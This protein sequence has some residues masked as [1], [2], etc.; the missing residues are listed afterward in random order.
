MKFPGQ[1]VGFS[2]VISTTG[3]GATYTCRL[4][5]ETQLLPSV[6]TTVYTVVAVGLAITKLPE[7]VL[8]PSSGDQVYESAPLANIE[9]ESPRQTSAGSGLKVITGRGFTKRSVVISESQP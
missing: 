6:P 4:A 2:V 1:T 8:R 7:V 9:R 5:V 3:M